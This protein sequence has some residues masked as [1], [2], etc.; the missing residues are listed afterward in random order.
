MGDWASCVE[1]KPDVKGLGDC[2]KA[3]EAS[4]ISEIDVGHKGPFGGI[5]LNTDYKERWLSLPEP[6]RELAP[7]WRFSSANM[8]PRWSSPTSAMT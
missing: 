7:E 5:L 8:V 1:E 4:E 2:E 6:P 3:Y